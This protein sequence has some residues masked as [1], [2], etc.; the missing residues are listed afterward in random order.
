MTKFFICVT[1]GSPFSSRFPRSRAWLVGEFYFSHNVSVNSLGLSI[2]LVTELNTMK[3]NVK[4]CNSL[5]IQWNTI[6]INLHNITVR[7][8]LILLTT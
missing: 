8:A 2:I 5:L 6:Q 3:S 1:E 4:F 7:Q